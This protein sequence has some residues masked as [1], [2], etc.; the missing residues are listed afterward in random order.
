MTRVQVAYFEVEVVGSDGRNPCNIDDD[1]DGVSDADEL[2]LGTVPSAGD[3]DG[4]GCGDTDEVSL[5]FNPADRWDWWNPSGDGQNRVDDILVV[6]Q[7]YFDKYL[8]SPPAP[9]LTLNPLYTEA[10]DRTA[11]GP[12]NGQQR[13]DDILKMVGYYFLDCD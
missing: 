8:S 6:V 4:D 13:V 3:T 1:G 5:G 9:P 2:S 7:Q 11:A 12:P 10:T